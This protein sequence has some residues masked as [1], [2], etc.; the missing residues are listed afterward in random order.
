[1]TAPPVK[2][3]VVVSGMAGAGKTTAARAL[4]DLGYFVVDNLPAPLIEPLVALS[5]ES[6]HRLAF[7]VDAREEPFLEEFPATWARLHD[8]GH[9][10][11][12][13]FLDCA[14]DVLVR[15]YQETRRRHPLD[16]GE[17][18][19][20]GGGGHGLLAAIARERALLDDLKGRADAI[21][22]TRALS[23]HELKRLITERFGDPTATLHAT[24]LSFGFKHGLP[25]EL[26]LC[27]DA[28]FLP[29]PFFVEG[30]RRKSGL[31]PDVRD[32]VLQQKDTGLFLDKVVDLVG[33]LLPS[34]AAEGKSYVTVAVGCTGGR[35][36]SV[37][38]VEEAVALLRE[39]GFDVAARHRDLDRDR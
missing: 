15:R 4:E 22:D 9:Q 23:V 16:A 38:L 24:L 1:M 11:L 27:F 19:E 29:N 37:A 36:R 26:D 12:L 39:A 30:L 13:L 2:R 21:V 14:D 5:G 31:D 10:L 20:A 17:H 8:A 3:I 28:R 35:H 18:G 34:F 33:F 32:F 7:V 25:A 6:R